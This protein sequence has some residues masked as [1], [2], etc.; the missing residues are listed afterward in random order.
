MKVKN[1]IKVI[2][3]FNNREFQILSINEVFLFIFFLTRFWFE[4]VEVILKY[5]W[6]DYFLIMSIFLLI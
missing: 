3:L 5:R 1:F 6:N 2:R 4:I